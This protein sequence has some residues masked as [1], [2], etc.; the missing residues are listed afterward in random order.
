MKNRLSSIQIIG[1]QRSG[2]NLLRLIL[3]QFEEISAPHPPHVLRTFVPLLEHYGNLNLKDNFY[4]LASDIADFVNANPVSWNG[5][6][7]SATELVD[8]SR[9]NS[10]LSL[11]EILYVIKAQQDNARIWCCKSMFNEYYAPEMETK[12]IK[13]FYIYM[14]RDGRDVAASF[15]K[16][17]IGPKHVYHIANKWLKD[18]E[19]A[20]QVLELIGEARFFNIKYEDL[21]TQPEQVLKALSHKLGLEYSSDLLAYYE[22]SESRRTAS[23]GDMWKNV[24]KPII[25]SN[26][27]KYLQEL[28]ANEIIIFE[29]IAGKM[30]SALGYSPSSGSKPAVIEYS[31]EQIHLFN[32]QNQAIQQDVRSRASKQELDHRS[33]QEEILRAI[34]DRFGLK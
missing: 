15:K 13:P 4:L 20:Q 12:G 34:H 6:K 25:S 5:H 14:Y 29:N 33:K 7:L 8:R 19:K 22:S 30:L 26:I 16:A 2:S 31:A 18:Q 24:A 17:I 1:T 23:S 9:D 32:K 27:G 21:I 10:L 28:T 11:Y 3:N